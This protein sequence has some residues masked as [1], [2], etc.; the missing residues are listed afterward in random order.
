MWLRSL[1]TVEHSRYLDCVK[2][3]INYSDIENGFPTEESLIKC[4]GR[5]AL[6]EKTFYD[7]LNEIENKA[8]LG[9]TRCGFLEDIADG[10]DNPEEK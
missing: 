9:Y 6:I 4:F 8:R 7:F 1:S 10:N 5:R 3:G 2:N